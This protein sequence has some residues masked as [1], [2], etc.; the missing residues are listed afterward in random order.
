MPIYALGDRRPTIDPTAYI[1]P[2][3]V[4]IGAVTIGAGATI[5]PGAVLRGDRGCIV[6][7]PETSVQDGSVLH[8]TAQHDTVVGARCV[9][10]HLAHLE[11]CTIFDNSLVGSGAVVLAGAQ[12]GPVAMV[13]AAALVPPGVGIPRGARGLGVPAR[14][15]HDAFAMADIEPLVE[16]Y[17][18]NGHWYAADLKPIES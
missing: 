16:T 4:I 17:I 9:I 1:H 14:I 6:I 5:W 15:Q 3:A 18:A 8:C 2:D 13:G 10:G 11:G 12:V 7:G